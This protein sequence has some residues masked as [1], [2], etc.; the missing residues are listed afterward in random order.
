MIV[1][2]AIILVYRIGFMALVRAVPGDRLRD[3]VFPIWD[4]NPLA[5]HGFLSFNSAEEFA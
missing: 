2:A 1:C 3:I 4:S 5:A